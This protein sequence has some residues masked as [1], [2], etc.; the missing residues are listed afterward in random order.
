MTERDDNILQQNVMGIPCNWDEKAYHISFANVVSKPPG[1]LFDTSNILPSRLDDKVR[2]RF[3]FQAKLDLDNRVLLARSILPLVTSENL[4]DHLRV[5]AFRLEES[6]SVM[7]AI[8]YATD[9]NVDNG[10]GAITD[11]GITKAKQLFLHELIVHGLQMMENS[12]ITVS[13]YQGYLHDIER[14]RFML[15]K[16]EQNPVTESIQRLSL[17]EWLIA[18]KFINEAIEKCPKCGK[19]LFERQEKC[20]YCYSFNEGGGD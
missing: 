18:N 17:G 11:D 9:C 2:K 8:V 6:V 7:N 4:R 14:M 1:W 19:C 5:Y 12:D 20:L 16:I 13:E 10:I 15:G 3:I